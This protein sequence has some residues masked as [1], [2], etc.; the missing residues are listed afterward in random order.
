MPDPITVRD[1]R[2]G[3]L[4]V[5]VEFNAA[6]ALET[7]G[8]YLDRGRLRAGTLAVLESPGRGFYRVAEL[9]QEGGG[10]VVGQLLITAEWSDWRNAAFWW[11]QSVY[12]HPDWRR[13]GVYRSLHESVLRDARRRPDVCGVRLYVDRDNRIAQT[14]YTR[15]G[16]RR[17]SYVMFEEDFVLDTGARRVDP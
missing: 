3:D 5:L 4:D 9:V 12:V 13:R 7:E 15:V 6:M 10:R 16:L 14:V 11:L 1:A 17:S 8:R 2:L